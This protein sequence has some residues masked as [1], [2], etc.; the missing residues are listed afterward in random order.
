MK[1][2]LS[3]ILLSLFILNLCISV[4]A[5][6]FSWPWRWFRRSTRVSTSNLELSLDTSDGRSRGTTTWWYDISGKTA[7]ATQSIAGQRPTISGADKL[8][9]STR[10]FDGTDDNMS[11]TARTVTSWTIETWYKPDSVSGRYPILD[12]GDFFL[13]Q[14]DD[15]LDYGF[16]ATSY[17]DKIAKDSTIF[18]ANTWYHLAATKSG[19]DVTLYLDG[20]SSDTFSSTANLRS[21]TNLVLGAD[22]RIAFIYPSLTASNLSGENTL[23]VNASDLVEYSIG[24]ASLYSSTITENWNDE[25]F[26]IRVWIE[27]LNFM[28]GDGLTH[29]ILDNQGTSATENRVQLYISSAGLLIF[30]VDDTTPTQHLVSYDITGWIS[31]S[32][33]QIVARLDLKSNEIELYTDGVSRDST[34]DNALSSDTIDTIEANTH[35]G[36]DTSDANQLNGMGTLQIFSRSWSD[37]E[38]TADWNSGSGVAFVVDP[39]T[40]LMANFS[41][42]E[43]GIVYHHSGKSVSAIS[44]GG[45][46][47]TLTTHEGTDNSFADGNAVIVSDGTGFSKQGYVDGSPSDT[48]LDI[49]DGA[50]AAVANIAQVGVSIDCNGSYF[51]EAANNTIHDVALEDLCISTRVKVDSSAGATLQVVT[52]SNVAPRWQL[53]IDSGIVFLYLQDSD[54]DTYYLNGDTDIRDNKWH[55]IAAVLDRDNAANCKI[56]LDGIEN[57][58]SKSGTLADLGTLAN[59]HT[60]NIGARNNGDFILDGQIADVKLYYA[61]GAIWSDAEVL[62]QA[63]HPFNYGASAGTLTDYWECTENTGTTVNGNVNNLTLSNADAWSQ[64]AYVS[65]NLIVDSGMESGSIGAIA[66]ASIDSTITVSKDTSVVHSDTQSTKVV[67]AASNDDVELT[68]RAPI[69]ESGSDY[70]YRFWSKIASNSA[71]T[72][73]EVDVDGS[74]NVLN[75]RLAGVDDVGNWVGNTLKFDGSEWVEGGTDASLDITDTITAEAWIKI[76][77]LGEDRTLL[78]KSPQNSSNIDYS[79]TVLSTGGFRGGFYDGTWK[80]IRSAGSLVVLNQWMH[81]VWTYDRTNHYLYFNGVQIGTDTDSIAMP[82]LGELEIGRYYWDTPAGYVTGNIA[83]VRIYNIALTAADALWLSTH[84]NA[85]LADIYTNTSA[86]QVGGAANDEIV[87]Y[88]NYRNGDLLDLTEYGNDGTHSGTPSYSNLWNVHEGTLQ[89]DQDGT[90]DINLRIDGAGANAATVY[91]DSMELRKQLVVSGD[92]EAADGNALPTGWS[93]AGSPDAAET[94]TDTSDFHSGTSSILLNGCDE[95]EGVTQDII[96]VVRQKYTLSFWEKNDA[97]DV[98]VVLSDAITITID[99]TGDNT[100]SGQSYTFEATTT[101]LTLSMVAGAA[102]QSGWFDDLSI[103]KLDEADASTATRTRDFVDGS[104]EK[105]RVWSRSLTAA[106]IQRQFNKERKQHSK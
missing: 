46:E 106:E 74:G 9:G 24:S 77:I 94:Q 48:E 67:Y 45:T 98:D 78:M 92:C 41:D 37:A 57:N 70:W 52:K 22:S 6:A 8:S 100:W 90:H 66:D 15:D 102:G 29:Y 50:G 83:A 71:N 103:L 49:D 75:R 82:T 19:N 91:I 39:D 20:Q 23:L 2:K 42:D 13:R 1:R 25:Q 54:P 87:L 81:V 32:D 76:D 35:F 73:I 93:D 5:E 64:E 26:T 58:T 43:T 28:P 31:G 80:E 44:A 33:H 63:T 88:H 62:Y 34:P 21:E 55:H 95:N 69:L 61:T 99:T 11:L 53:Y 30:D 104:I 40:I 10:V 85:S 18:A 68:F 101:T 56:F 72:N 96:V 16:L 89:G 51:A 79:L 38:V 3:L 59:T 60:F 12:Q 97:Q 105:V 65:K 14:W 7:H 47:A 17:I 84:P 36:K 27:S 86:A 4:N